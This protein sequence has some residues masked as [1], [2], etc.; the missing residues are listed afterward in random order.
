VPRSETDEARFEAVFRANYE[1]VLAYARRRATPEGAADAASEAFLAA[2]RRLDQL[3][4]QPLPW[5]LGAARRALANQRRGQ[6]RRNSL[7]GRLRLER[8]EDDG[9]LNALV[10][11]PDKHLAL[12]LSR[13]SARDREL[14]LL[15]AW[16]GLTPRE[17]ALTMGLSPGA[18]RV[19]LH[20]TKRRVASLLAEA[21][22]NC[23]QPSFASLEERP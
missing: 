11:G 10:E 6:A 18:T 23:S 15:V 19:R 8:E 4:E 14:L 21:D 7:L 13:V 17:A 16:E 3:P 12:A 1:R 20:R 22:E 2:W 9:A 5:L